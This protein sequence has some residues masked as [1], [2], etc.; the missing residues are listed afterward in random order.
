MSRQTSRAKVWWHA[1]RYHFVTPSI[2]PAV[3]GGLVSWANGEFY[4]WLFI[5]VL[6]VIII[7]HIGLNM[8]DDYFDYKQAVDRRKPGEKNPY[9]GGS[10]ALSDGAIKPKEM[11]L[12]FSLC[13]L[14]TISA[15][16][17]LTAIR[18]LPVLLFGLFGVFCAIFYTAPPVSFSHHGF[19]ELLILVNFGC[20]IGLGAYYVQSQT[21]TLEAF[22]ATLPIGLMVFSMIVINEIPDIEEDRSAG[23]FTLIVRYG[24][25]AGIK[26]YTVS[27]LCVYAI[28]LGAVA[29]SLIPVFTLLALL[30]LPHVLR[31]TKI[32]RQHFNNPVLMAPSNLG[33]IKALS[34]ASFGLIV[35]YSIQGILNGESLT[36]LA[37]ALLILV[38]TCAPA[39]IA[40]M[41]ARTE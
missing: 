33:T 30:S 3:L 10:G 41:H 6:I 8:T 27:W 40:V 1:I 31:S 34:V 17:Y 13:F 18:G 23:K 9:T 37:I 19:G 38:A 14:I 29:L 32:L 11:F 16:L 2:F 21:F 7:N 24:R 12:A 22:L 25:A 26:L 15:G 4:L 28:I 36:Q 35:G 39:A 20:I 5:L